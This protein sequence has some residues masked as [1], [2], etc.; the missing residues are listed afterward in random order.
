MGWVQDLI[1]W[2]PE[3]GA[4][5]EVISTPMELP[6][7]TLD[8]SYDLVMA[9]LTLWRE[10]RGEPREGKVAIWHVILNRINAGWGNTVVDIV[11]APK[12]FSCYNLDD[13]QVNLYPKH[14]DPAWLECWSVV[15]GEDAN[16]VDGA[17]NYFNPDGADPAW[18]KQLV[19]VARIGRH[20][21]YRDP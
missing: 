6:Q 19:E 21:F 18:A 10:A 5:V 1:G 20:V 2:K 7:I 17:K 14:N 15:N 4:P 9:A 8:H 12:Q 11:L 16:P 3:P 13:P